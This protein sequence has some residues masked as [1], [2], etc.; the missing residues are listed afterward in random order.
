[1]SPWQRAT[2]DVSACSGSQEAPESS[3]GFPPIGP[4]SVPQATPT[5]AAGAARDMARLSH[6]CCGE[7]SAPEGHQHRRPQGPHRW[8]PPP[9]G[10]QPSAA[11][12]FPL[13]TSPGGSNGRSRLVAARELQTERQTSPRERAGHMPGWGAHKT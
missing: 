3:C 4:S 5:R 12:R 2:G 13:L 7:L 8:P 11:T 9:T 6:S 10:W 1:V